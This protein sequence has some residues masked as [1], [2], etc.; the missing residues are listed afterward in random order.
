[1]DDE[2]PVG[3]LDVP[4]DRAS[5]RRAIPRDFSSLRACLICG[6]IKSES[7][8]RET[9]CENCNSEFHDAGLDYRSRAHELITKSY[10]G[11]A[12]PCNA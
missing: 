8:F 7:Q 2:D 6:L 9:G 4:F 12:L 3:T 1:M 11:S 5:Q 10:K